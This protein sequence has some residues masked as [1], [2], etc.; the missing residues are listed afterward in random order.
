MGDLLDLLLSYSEDEQVNLVQVPDQGS[1][2]KGAVVQIQGVPAVGVIDSG[3]DITIMGAELFAKVA[4]TARLRKRD[5]KKLDRTPRTYDQRTFTL[6]GRLDLDIEY[7]GKSMRTPVYLRTAAKDQLLLSEGVCR[8]LGIIKYHPE[9]GLLKQLIKNPQGL[10]SSCDSTEPAIA[11][12]PMVRVLLVES[13]NVLPHQS[14][15]VAVKIDRQYPNEATLLVEPFIDA[16]VQVEEALVNA[17]SNCLA[18]VVVNNASGV[19][20][21]VEKGV[22]LGSAIEVALVGPSEPG[23]IV[24]RVRDEPVGDVAADEPR[25]RKLLGM[26]KKSSLLGEQEGEFNSF[27]AGFHDVFS[28]EEGERR[29]TDLTEMVINTGDSPPRR[30]P[31]RRM[32]LA[33]RREVSKQLKNMQQA[34]VIQPSA[35]PLVDANAV[36]AAVVTE[37]DSISHLLASDL[38]VEES[39]PTFAEEQ[40]KDPDICSLLRFLEDASQRIPRGPRRLLCRPLCSQ[41]ATTSYITLTLNRLIGRG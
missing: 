11:E 14:L 15:E 21:Q 3:S 6:D 30:V 26:V 40:R 31:A 9:V 35:S 36:V 25:K 24:N 22:C 10:I 4:P 17:R 32:P 7:A 38:G 8:Q 19:S 23:P 34:G 29:E 27:L 28:L 37:P 5:L 16:A 33:V 18:R 39:T 13:I 2:A 1:S 12:V 41:Y 20:C